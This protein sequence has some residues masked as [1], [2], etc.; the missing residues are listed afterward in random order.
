MRPLVGE[1]G[2]ERGKGPGGNGTNGPVDQPICQIVP[3]RDVPP[4]GG[5]VRG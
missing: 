1:S 4:A 5:V 2:E 3:N